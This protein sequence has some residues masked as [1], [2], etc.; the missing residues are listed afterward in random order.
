ML[1][2]PVDPFQGAWLAPGYS[3]EPDVCPYGPLQID[4]THK[5]S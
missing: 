1:S 2:I 5:F 4:L 3:L